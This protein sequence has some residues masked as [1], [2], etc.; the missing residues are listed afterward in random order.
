MTGRFQGGATGDGTHSGAPLPVGNTPL[1]F[2]DASAVIG[3]GTVIWHY[4]V[5]LADVQIGSHCSV[6]SGTEI[7]RGSIIG[8]DSRIG[9]RV[10]LPS[11][12]IIGRHVFIS[13]G[14]IC[15][16][17]KYPRVNHLTYHAE[18]PVIE[19]HVTIG[20]AAILLPGVRIGR[21]A[22]IAAGAIVTHDVPADAL[23]RGTP[24]RIVWRTPATE[25][26]PCRMS[27]TSTP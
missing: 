24:A 8:D 4:A 17:D 1:N 12:S 2:I 21:G 25:D 14:V 15:C 18:P 7:G 16:D 5:V 3:E 13:P 9:A 19:D 26:K 6:G 20:A 11:R 22:F 23:V 10:F 27:E